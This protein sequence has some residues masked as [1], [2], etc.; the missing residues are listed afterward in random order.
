MCLLII[1]L[2]LITRTHT[3][4]HTH[5]QSVLLRQL[6]SR[7]VA[8]TWAS[9]F[10]YGLIRINII[11]LLLILSLYGGQTFEVSSDSEG[12]LTVSIEGIN[13]FEELPGL[14]DVSLHKV[15][16][17]RWPKGGGQF[18]FLAVYVIGAAAYQLGNTSNCM[19]TEVK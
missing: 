7:A 13:W 6:A 14:S 16:W 9:P 15:R 8:M 17:H 3:H 11:G 1:L 5:T 2:D 12:F 18:S 19:I 10:K 4:T